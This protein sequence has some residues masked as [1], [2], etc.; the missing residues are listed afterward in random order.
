[1]HPKEAHQLYQAGKAII[2]D[3]R[4]EEEL[5]ESGMAE[6]SLWMPCSK[7]TEDDAEWKAFREKLPKDKTICFYCRSGARSGRVTEAMKLEGI[8]AV[9]IGGLKDWKEAGLPTTSFR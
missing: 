4:E 6:N 8:E 3:V 9:N 7:M 5:R 1:M 2:V